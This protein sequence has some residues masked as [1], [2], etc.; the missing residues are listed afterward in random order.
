[1]VDK[2]IR[3]ANENMNKEIFDSLINYID[4]KIQYELASIEEDEDGYTSSCVFERKEMEMAEK[5]LYDL[6]I[7]KDS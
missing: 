1:M 4:K 2:A 7:N 3:T 6:Y 5:K